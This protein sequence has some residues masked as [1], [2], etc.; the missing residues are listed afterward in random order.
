MME[1]GRTS[2]STLDDIDLKDMKNDAQSS[3][4]KHAHLRCS[5][6]VLI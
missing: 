4:G 2:V 1:F 5:F 6:M 3:V